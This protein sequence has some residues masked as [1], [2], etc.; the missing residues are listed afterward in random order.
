MSIAYYRPPT[1]SYKQRSAAR[2]AADAERQQ[3][4]AP[5]TDFYD[6]PADQRR[7]I[8]RAAEQGKAE[9]QQLAKIEE[10]A[11]KQAEID[12]TPEHE[13]R[14]RNPWRDLIELR[15]PDAWRKE[16][17]HRIKVYEKEARAE[18]E[19]IDRL[20]EEKLKRHELESAPEYQ[21]ALEHWQRATL[22]ADTNEQQELA[23]LKG[24]IDGGAASHYWDEVAPLMRGRLQKVQQRME[25]QIGKQAIVVG[26]SKAMAA[27]LE[28][29]SELQVETETPNTEQVTE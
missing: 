8:R 26:E 2:R 20:M 4:S 10:Q 27:E 1:M 12:S 19:R 9:A 3:Q 7:A 5:R 13:R 18:D 29:A 21:R 25:E 11:K 28:A 22:N 16:V 15:R 6:L 17:A 23:R 14:P 24:M